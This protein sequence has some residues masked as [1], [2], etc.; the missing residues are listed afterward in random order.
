M[1]MGRQL[2]PQANQQEALVCDLDSRICSTS[3]TIS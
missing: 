1:G 2:M 3:S